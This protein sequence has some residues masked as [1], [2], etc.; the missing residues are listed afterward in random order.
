MRV[1]KNWATPNRSWYVEMNA[2]LNNLGL[3]FDMYTGAETIEKPIPI[4]KNT[5]SVIKM[6]QVGANAKT[7]VPNRKNN[8]AYCIISFPSLAIHE[9]TS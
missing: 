2:P 7:V 9:F 8:A 3:I 1:A 4:P 6:Y 5:R